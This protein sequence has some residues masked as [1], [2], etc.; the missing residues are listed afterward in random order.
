MAVDKEVEISTKVTEKNMMHLKD[1]D[2]DLGLPCPTSSS[3]LKAKE[4]ADDDSIVKT[5]ESLAK[6]KP[7]HLICI[8][9]RYHED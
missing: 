4:E 1:A 6:L 5:K 8:S 2:L 9:D 3:A 7:A